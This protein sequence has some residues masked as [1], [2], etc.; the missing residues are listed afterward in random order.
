MNSERQ[1][2]IVIRE[3]NPG[4]APNNPAPGFTTVR[5]GPGLFGNYG[6]LDIYCDIPQTDYAFVVLLLFVSLP[7]FLIQS[8][9]QK[10]FTYMLTLILSTTRILSFKYTPNNLLPTLISE[11]GEKT[12]LSLFSSS[13]SEYLHRNP[14]THSSPTSQSLPCRHPD[15]DIEAQTSTLPLSLTLDPIISNGSRGNGTAGPPPYMPSPTI[16]TLSHRAELDNAIT[17]LGN[18]TQGVE[19][20]EDIGST[21]RGYGK[22]GEFPGLER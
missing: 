17:A 13:A 8:L 18:M 6:E 2:I 3:G 11:A 4:D 19:E 1:L 5:F 12:K 22:D 10:S 21:I 7:A 16:G 9:T 15:I 20:E 14:S